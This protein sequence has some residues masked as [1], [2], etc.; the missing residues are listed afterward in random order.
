MKQ[1]HLFWFLG[2]VVVFVIVMIALAFVRGDVL[3]TQVAVP[4]PVAEVP[5]ADSNDGNY[6]AIT[7]RRGIPAYN[8]PAF[9]ISDVR[10]NLKPEYAPL[11]SRPERYYLTSANGIGEQVFNPRYFIS[12]WRLVRYDGMEEWLYDL[13]RTANQTRVVDLRG[14]NI[15]GA[16]ETAAPPPNRTFYSRLWRTDRVPIEVVNNALKVTIRLE[17]DAWRGLDPLRHVYVDYT[18]TIDLARVFEEAQN[19]PEGEA[20]ILVYQNL[21]WTAQLRDLAHGYDAPVD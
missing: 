13:E 6:A 3:R 9:R 21:N 16:H 18:A 17:A 14:F 11:G 15:Q 5:P 4:P 2:V 10:V 8:E 20:Y 7:V 1:Q 12:W 19:A